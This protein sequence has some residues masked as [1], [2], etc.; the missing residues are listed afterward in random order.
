MKIFKYIF[1]FLFIPDFSFGQTNKPIGYPNDLNIYRGGLSVDS[2]IHVPVRSSAT[3]WHGLHSD[4]INEGGKIKYWDQGSNSYHPLDASDAGFVHYS[5]TTY[6]IATKHYAGSL[7]DGELTQTISGLTSK[8]F[9]LSQPV[10][11]TKHIIIV[12]N[13][14]II[15]PADYTI[16]GQQVTLSFTPEA[17]DKFLIYI[18]YSK[19]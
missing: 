11:N 2:F 16:S 12:M 10:D 14:G 1:L 17:T 13:S 9:I 5:D 15:Y 8:T 18:K 19:Q 4:F 3:T 7:I 6:L